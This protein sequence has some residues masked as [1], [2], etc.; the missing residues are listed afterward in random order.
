MLQQGDI[1]S[2]NSSNSVSSGGENRGAQPGATA[3]LRRWVSCLCL[4]WHR[5][6]GGCHSLPPGQPWEWAAPWAAPLCPRAEPAAWAPLR[7]AEPA[8]TADTGPIRKRQ[9][10][11]L[12]ATN[13]PRLPKSRSCS[14]VLSLEL[15]DLTELAVVER[16]PRNHNTAVHALVSREGTSGKSFRCPGTTPLKLR[17]GHPPTL[18]P[19]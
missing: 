5:G 7:V 1:L 9:A 10:W 14:Y 2:S 19:Q 13:F 16:T 4:G 8:A 17:L 3:I 11:T 12:R 6:A 18:S 15:K